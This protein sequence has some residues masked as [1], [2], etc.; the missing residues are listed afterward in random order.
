MKERTG[1]RRDGDGNRRDEMGKGQREREWERKLDGR[2]ESLGGA[3]N[4]GR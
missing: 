4:L 3:R 1:W 2:G